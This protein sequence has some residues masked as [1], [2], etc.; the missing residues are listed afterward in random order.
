MGVKNSE[1]LKNRVGVQTSRDPKKPKLTNNFSL[2][3]SLK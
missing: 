3:M 2:K 1:K